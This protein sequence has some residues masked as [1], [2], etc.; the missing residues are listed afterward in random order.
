MRGG[1]GDGLLVPDGVIG[2]CVCVC[3]ACLVL[4]VVY[5][6]LKKLESQIE[7]SL[8]AH[9]HDVNSLGRWAIGAAALVSQLRFRLGKK[10]SCVYFSVGVAQ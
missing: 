10:P 3:R 4:M 1:L 5:N 2:V 9:P 7:P 6:F 8:A